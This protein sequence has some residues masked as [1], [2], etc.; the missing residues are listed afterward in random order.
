MRRVAEYPDMECGWE[1]S[2]FVKVDDLLAILA[3]IDITN[4]DGATGFTWQGPDYADRL[5]AGSDLERLLGGLLEQLGDETNS[6]DG[7]PDKR[8]ETYFAAIN[9]LAGRV[10]DR[11]SPEEAPM[12]AIEAVLRLARFRQYI[13]P[14]R[15]VKDVGRERIELPV[16]DAWRSGAQRSG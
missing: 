16:G 12:L 8:E 5:S 10:L 13:Q 3:K 6:D 14:Y 11:C 9:A 15:T 7:L 4:N 2:T 1:L